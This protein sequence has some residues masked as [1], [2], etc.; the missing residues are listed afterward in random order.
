MRHLLKPI[1]LNKMPIKGVITVVKLIPRILKRFD[2]RYKYLDPTNKFIQKYVPPGYRKTAFKIKRYADIGITAAIIY[3]LANTDNS[4]RIPQKQQPYKTGQTRN[5]M[6]QYR[7]KR[8]YDNRYTYSKRRRCWIKRSSRWV[9]CRFTYTIHI[10]RIS[11]LPS[12]RCRYQCYSL[13]NYR[14]KNRSD[15]V[16]W[17]FILSK[18]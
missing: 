6:E 12:R 13:E 14:Q 5:Y 2:Q 18:W 9:C 16:H 10:F 11:F 17:K 4:A 1:R 3:D 8:Q 15:Y 7:S